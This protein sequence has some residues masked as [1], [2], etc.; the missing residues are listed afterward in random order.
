MKALGLNPSR[1]DLLDM[2]AEV[3]TDR[4]GT[5]DFP[6]FCQLMAMKLVGNVSEENEIL[7]AFKVFD[8]D[9]NG[10][11]SARELRTVMASLGRKLTDEEVDDIIREVDL[12]GDGQIDYE[13][14]LKMMAVK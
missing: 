9:G 4:N 13:E 1:D 14:F 12:D 5:V 2:I 6:E 8:Q 3:D 11:I 7:E 10:Y